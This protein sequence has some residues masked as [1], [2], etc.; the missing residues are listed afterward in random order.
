MS[1]VRLAAL[2]FLL[3]LCGC[4]K[5]EAPPDEG[6]PKPPETAPAAQ[7]P[8]LPPYEDAKEERA[9]ERK[10]WFDAMD[11][12][13]RETGDSEARDVAAFLKENA[14]LCAPTNPGPGLTGIKVL[15]EGRSANYVGITP[16]LEKDRKSGGDVFIRSAGAFYNPDARIIALHHQP[17]SRYWKGILLLHEGHH[18]YVMT[19]KPYDWQDVRTFCVKEKETHQFQ[20]RIMQKLGGARYDM[21]VKKDMERMRDV[22]KKEGK[23]IKTIFVHRGE[24]DDLLDDVFEK[25]LSP[26]E[27]D[28]RAT[29]IW[30]DAVFRLVDELPDS[31]AEKEEA[32]ALILKTLY[33]EKGILPGQ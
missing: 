30:V 21:V 31:P 3:A 17:I 11:L 7:D 1:S 25:A 23:S 2:A 8:P 10:A 22:M 18:S 29:H 13:T 19:Y 4:S 5:K 20:N 9:V 15:E 32:K 24:Y 16:L 6:N 12:V 27:K 14:I 33:A 26:L 28:L